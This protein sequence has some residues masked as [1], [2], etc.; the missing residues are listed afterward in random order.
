[1]R[2]GTKRALDSPYT[3]SSRK[4]TAMIREETQVTDAK[5]LFLLDVADRRV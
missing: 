5:S 1:M 4:T 3:L 2:P